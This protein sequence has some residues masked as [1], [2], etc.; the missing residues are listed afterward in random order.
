MRLKKLA[1][2]MTVCKVSTPEEALTGG[3]CFAR[4]LCQRAGGRHGAI[5]Q[6]DGGG[7]VD[8]STDEAVVDSGRDID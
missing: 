1:R 5:V 3:Q 6:L 8:G 7:N 4:Q 2:P